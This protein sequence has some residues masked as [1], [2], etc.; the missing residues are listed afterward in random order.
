VEN[1]KVISHKKEYYAHFGHFKN[2]H[3]SNGDFQIGKKFSSFPWV[4]GTFKTKG[5]LFVII[6]KMIT[7]CIII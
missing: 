2:V 4:T 3:F 1:L 5:Y 6:L 7:K